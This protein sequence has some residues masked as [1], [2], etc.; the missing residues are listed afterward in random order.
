MRF[1]L[2]VYLFLTPS[3]DPHPIM[4]PQ[5]TA[6]SCEKAGQKLRTDIQAQT[7]SATTVIVCIDTGSAY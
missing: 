7:P 1:L 6:V 4:I 2:I 3:G 5:S